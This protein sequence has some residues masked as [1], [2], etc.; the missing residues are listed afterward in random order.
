M[1][2]PNNGDPPFHFVWGRAIQDSNLKPTATLVAYAF[3]QF[4]GAD[5]RNPPDTVWLSLSE[6][7]RI[8]RLSRDAANRGTRNLREA[9]W[10]TPVK[11]AAQHRSVLYR[12]VIPPGQ[13]YVSHTTERSVTRTGDNSSGTPADTSSTSCDTRSTAAV[14]RKGKPKKIQEDPSLF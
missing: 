6:L 4:V 14:P 3:G 11:P 10:L 13:Q 5:K 1:S 12:A 2:R 7:Q 8:T 9:G